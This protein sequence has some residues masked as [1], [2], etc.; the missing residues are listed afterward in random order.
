MSLNEL[1][2]RVKA[3]RARSKK[4]SSKDTS[5]D[6][7]CVDDVL[8]AIDRLGK[9]GG[10]V[11]AIPNGKNYII[12]S[13]ASELSMDNVVLLQKAQENNGHVDK[14]IL[15]N[16][17]GWSE[18]RATKALDDMVKEGLV[19]VDTQTDNSLTWYWFPGLL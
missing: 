6:E 16:K 2:Q 11:K 12:Q 10:G 9:L 18:E 1:L 14:D 13:V 8:R 3:S 17:L 19:W 15:I 5:V 7:V 4:V